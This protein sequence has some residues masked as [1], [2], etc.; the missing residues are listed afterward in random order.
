MPLL[1]SGTALVR[2]S[3]RTPPR[4]MD[5]SAAPDGGH[6]ITTDMTRQERGGGITRAA[7]GTTRRRFIT[8]QGYNRPTGI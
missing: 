6:T 3:R 8:E 1:D 2:P 4:I 5:T 7:E